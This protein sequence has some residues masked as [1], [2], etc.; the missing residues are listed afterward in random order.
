MDVNYWDDLTDFYDTL[1]EHRGDSH[2]YIELAKKHGGPLLEYG[3]GTG[4]LLLPIAEQ[5]IECCGIDSSRKMLDVLENKVSNSSQTVKQNLIFKHGDFNSPF[6]FGIKFGMIIMAAVTTGLFE[7]LVKFDAAIQ[8]LSSNLIKSEGYLLLERRANSTLDFPD[9]K[10]TWFKWWKE[11]KMAVVYYRTS[12]IMGTGYREDIHYFE[13]MDQNGNISKK[14]FPIKIW[15]WKLLEVEQVLDKYGMRIVH[16]WGDW[17][18]N[19]YEERKSGRII[20]LA[21]KC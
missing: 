6:S 7:G 18:F 10:F 19:E 16:K 2:F 14:D 5:G 12:K 8:H 21:Q 11:K 17:D 13:F 9:K 1:W 20:I 3:C 4:R 15:E